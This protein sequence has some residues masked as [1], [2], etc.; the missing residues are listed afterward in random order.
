MTN[1]QTDDERRSA[2]RAVHERSLQLL[3]DKDMRGWVDLWTDDCVF[4]FPFAPPG[5]PQRLEGRDAVWDY[6]KDYPSKIDLKAFHDVRYLHGADPDVLVVEMRSEGRAL[7]TDKP[8][9]MQYISIIT[10]RDGR[11]AHY[12]DYWNPLAVA[13]ALGGIDAFMKAFDTPLAATNAPDA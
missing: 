3:L 9:N 11:I 2:A 5:Y 8:Y 13:N 10:V 6:I 1:T 12:R 7:G 4:E